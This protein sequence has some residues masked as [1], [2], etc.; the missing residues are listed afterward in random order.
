MWLDPDFVH[1]TV[2]APRGFWLLAAAAVLVPALLFGVVAAHDR[3]RV[4]DDLARTVRGQTDIFHQH[5]LNVFETQFLAAERI[6]ERLA[7]MEWDGI[8][9][10]EPLHVFLQALHD[11]YPQLGAIWLAD[12]TGRLRAGNETLPAR[13]VSVA[14][15]D[16][17]ETL[18]TGTGE[19]SLG[20]LV[21]G[22]VS[23]RTS[24]DMAQRLQRPDGSFNGAVIITA[25]PAYFR[26]FWTSVAPQAVMATALV[27]GDRT[28]MMH[29]PDIDPASSLMPATSVFVRHVQGQERGWFR[30]VSAL[31][32]IERFYGFRRIGSYNAYLLHGVGVTSALGVWHHDL[33][34]YGSVCAGAAAALLGLAWLGHRRAE[35]ELVRSGAEAHKMELENLVLG[36]ARA[37]QSARTS[38]AQFRMLAE[39]SSD[40]IIRTGVDGIRRYM[41]PA[42]LNLSGYRPDELIGRHCTSNVHPDDIP[43]IEHA[44]RQLLA[45]S[46]RISAV[47][48]TLHKDGSIVWMEE[49]SN[50][51]RNAITGAAE[52][53]ITVA[54]DITARKHAEEAL[55]AANE[56]LAEQALTDGLTGLVNR[57]H[58]DQALE[59]EWRRAARDAAPLSLLLLDADCFKLYNDLYG[60]PMGDQVLRSIATS[61]QE[62]TRRSGDVGARYGGEEFTVILPNTFADGAITVAEFIRN[63]IATLRILHVHGP[64]GIVTVSVG[65]ATM[66][67][68]PGTTMASLLADADQA[69]YAAKS[70]GRN[71]TWHARA[72]GE[73]VCAAPAAG[74]CDSEAAPAADDGSNRTIRVAPA[75]GCGA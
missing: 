7:G 47:Y 56:A 41:S 59:R 13:P 68:S 73:A 15:R 66:V 1:R 67:P 49:Q 10:S 2:A 69:L 23:G 54:R 75:E 22:R 51:I 3:A 37:E 16:Y 33:V 8:A 42:T 12:P 64:A 45:G 5:A 4:L 35:T 31:D 65:A 52:E 39:H 28:V 20:G 50:L 72:L 14:D 40:A 26:D 36:L 55:A 34:V 24:F 46:P 19:L 11:K 17:F 58:F 48:R 44:L 9:R 43:I 21:V 25:D 29:T 63:G 57:R 32:G 61:I 74:L 70:A 71:Q 62:N 18:R 38:E 6:A 30:D 53:I 60:H 27:R